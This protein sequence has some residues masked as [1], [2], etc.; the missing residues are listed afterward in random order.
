MCQL[1][2]TISRKNSVKSFDG[3]KREFKNIKKTGT[4]KNLE[5]YSLSKGIHDRFIIIDDVVYCLGSSLNSF[6]KYDTV[7]YK[8]PNSKAVI[9]R[10][11][12]WRKGAKLVYHWEEG[13]KE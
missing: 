10:V 9:E 11:Q 4:I 6:G 5:V 7:L 3:V 2:L 8:S 1:I 13:V 12:Y